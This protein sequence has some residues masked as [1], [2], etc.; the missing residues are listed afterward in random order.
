MEYADLLYSGLILAAVMLSLWTAGLLAAACV[1][2][3][4]AFLD[5]RVTNHPR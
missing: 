1:C 2:F 3:A 4:P 5:P